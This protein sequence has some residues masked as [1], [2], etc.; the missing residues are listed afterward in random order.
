MLVC[1]IYQSNSFLMQSFKLLLL[2]HELT[3]IEIL[4]G[5]I[6]YGNSTQ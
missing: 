1:I 5:E 6:L 2:A 3:V 4:S